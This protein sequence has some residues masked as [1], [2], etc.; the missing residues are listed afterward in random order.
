M[1]G[2]TNPDTTTGSVAYSVSGNR[3]TVTTTDAKGNRQL[4]EFDARG[5]LVRR[6]EALDGINAEIN[7]QYDALGRLKQTRD[8][9][10]NVTSITYD[11]LGRKISMTE[12][13]SGTLA[14]KYND[15]GILTEQKDA[16]NQVQYFQYDEANRIIAEYW[17]KAPDNLPD[18]SYAYDDPAYANSK[19]RLTKVIDKSGE[20]H[21]SY[22]AKGNSKVWMQKVDG[23]E[24]AFEM[25]YDQQ[26][27]LTGL[28]YP[29]TSVFDRSY[30]D[31]GYLNSITKNGTAA[32]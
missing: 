24:F 7:Y 4:N 11:S 28:T 19:G 2:I 12:P 22:D 27:R 9:G 16:K 8:A 10:G 26:R 13:N 23:M 14:Y 31:A 3:A 5:R 15:L 18:I 21:F 1:T 32:S 20:S 30:D 29:D 17:N 6:V 25:A